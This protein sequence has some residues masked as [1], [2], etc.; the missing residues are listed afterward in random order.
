ML[1]GII[2]IDNANAND[3][4]VDYRMH[5]GVEKD[6]TE[7]TEG[8]VLPVIAVELAIMFY[9]ALLLFLVLFQ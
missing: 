1:E 8:D 4:H 3:S 9:Y 7:G 5:F 6:I 2:H